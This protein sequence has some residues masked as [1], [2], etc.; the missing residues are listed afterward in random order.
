MNKGQ[1]QII[2]TVDQPCPFLNHLIP[3]YNGHILLGAD[4][5]IFIQIRPLPGVGIFFK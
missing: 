5:E 3:Q 1:L 2:N 4:G